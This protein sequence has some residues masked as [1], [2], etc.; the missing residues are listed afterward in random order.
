VHYELGSDCMRGLGDG[1]KSN[2]I[3]E[4]P[5]SFVVNRKKRLI[6]Q[7][8]KH[9]ISERFQTP[10]FQRRLTF[11]GLKRIIF[12]FNSCFFHMLTRRPM[13]FLKILIV[14]FSLSDV[15]TRFQRLSSEHV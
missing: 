9:N 12:F 1:V 6:G 13:L 2:A 5:H 11:N 8:I 10:C 7:A 3:A 14:L 4:A 15:K